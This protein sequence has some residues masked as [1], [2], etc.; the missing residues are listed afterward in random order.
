MPA[1]PESTHGKRRKMSPESTEPRTTHENEVPP[2]AQS[3]VTQPLSGYDGFLRR[4]G[5]TERMIRYLMSILP[6]ATANALVDSHFAVSPSPIQG[7]GVFAT[8][9]IARDA[10]FPVSEGLVRYSLARYVNH[11]DAPNAVVSYD[12]SGNGW[13]RAMT[14]LAVGTEVTF[15]YEDSL[16]KSGLT[17]AALQ[18][19][20]EI[21]GALAFGAVGGQD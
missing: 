17:P 13:M 18:L 1:T 21:G 14:D 19:A 6:A 16:K 4:H 9:H 20:Q 2:A 3:R 8:R 7:L 12:E 11:S 5:L 10:V 15:D